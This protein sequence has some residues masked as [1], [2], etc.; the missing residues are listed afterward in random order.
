MFLKG[1][2]LTLISA[3]KC[4]FYSLV[5]KLRIFIPTLS[6]QKNRESNGF[7]KENTK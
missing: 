1:T 2:T 4:E 6:W 7:I 3:E 5:W